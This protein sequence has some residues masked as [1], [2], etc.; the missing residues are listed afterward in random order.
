MWIFTQWKRRVAHSA[1]QACIPMWELY[2]WLIFLR[3]FCELLYFLKNSILYSLESKG[4]GSFETQ[5]LP[6]AWCWRTEF[7]DQEKN[8]LKCQISTRPWGKVL[9]YK[10]NY[11]YLGN[12]N[13]QRQQLIPHSQVLPRALT[14]RMRNMEPFDEGTAAIKAYVLFLNLEGTLGWTTF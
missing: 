8:F 11:L 6:Q 4:P 10:R 1:V 7:R 5:Q 12:R 2:L 3:I 13:G 9:V 14:G